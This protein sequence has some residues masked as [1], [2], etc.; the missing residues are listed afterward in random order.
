L[1][2]TNASDDE[3]WQARRLTPEGDEEGLG[4]IPSK[5]RVERKEKSRLKNVKFQGKMFQDKVSAEVRIKA[6]RV[7]F[8]SSWHAVQVDFRCFQ[9]RQEF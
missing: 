6:E 8:F 9:A 5:K 4:I 7:G 2:V 1:H 3:W